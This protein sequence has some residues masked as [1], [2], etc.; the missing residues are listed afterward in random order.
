MNK[1]LNLYRVS[2]YYE[3]TLEN[4]DGKYE[5]SSEKDST[6]NDLYSRSQMSM[7]YHYINIFRNRCRLL[8]LDRASE[9]TVNQLNIPVGKVLVGYEI[10]NMHERYVTTKYV[11]KAS[12]F[13][14]H[15][16]LLYKIDGSKQEHC[17]YVTKIQLEDSLS[18]RLNRNIYIPIK[19]NTPVV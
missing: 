18:K 2:I 16:K 11:A 13:D 9:N 15:K 14:L 8:R 1:L 10:V 4:Y 3:L 17:Y 5:D 7:I 6:T 19:R 12:L